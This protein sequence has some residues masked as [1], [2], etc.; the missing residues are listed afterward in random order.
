MSRLNL[1]LLGL[2]GALLVSGCADTTE[3]DNKPVATVSEP[4]K[5]APA[6]EKADDKAAPA[7]AGQAAGAAVMDPETAKAP[8]GDAWTSDASS[9]IEFLGAKVSKTHTGG[10]KTFT[11]EAVSKDG[12]VIFTKFVVQTD[13]I[14]ADAGDYSAK[15][16][17]HLK[18]PD[19]FDVAKFPTAAFASTKI[20]HGDNGAATIT[21]N[22]KF[23]DVT[24]EITFP[25][26]FTEADG[27]VMAKADFQINRKDWG[28][29][30]KG[31]ADDLVK[32]E[33][34]LNL[35]LTFTK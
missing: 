27:K 7:E 13:S 32:D 20:E 14:W 15:L 28:L 33:V 29:D 5:E 6:A 22:L 12:K 4:A 26:T 31:K 10:F 21:G 19:F 18:D 25:A 35:A 11:G 8:E 34:A 3:I 16:T 23:I 1:T 24:K 17:G 2:A 30:Y 9:T